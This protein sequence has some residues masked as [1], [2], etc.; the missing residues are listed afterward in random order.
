M[1]HASILKNGFILAMC[2]ITLTILGWARERVYF[3]AHSLVASGVLSMII[4]LLATVTALTVGIVSIQKIKRRDDFIPLKDALAILFLP[5]LI[6]LILNGAFKVVLFNYI[7]PGYIELSRKFAIEA[8]MK[9]RDAYIKVMG[10][11]SFNA[12]LEWVKISNPYSVRAVAKSIT[13][14]LFGYL[15]LSLITA[16]SLKKGKTVP[17]S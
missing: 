15:I 9:S 5:I 13:T 3:K 2:F 6:A 14:S 4:I 17:E 12:R 7:D 1:R 10:D 11:S 16:F 8:M